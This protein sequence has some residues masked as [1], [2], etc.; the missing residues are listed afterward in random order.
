[1]IR[2]PWRAKPGE[3]HAAEIP[4][5]A[6][7]DLHG[8]VTRAAR[9][10]RFGF[11][12][13]LME[14]TAGIGSR[15]GR[16]VMTIL[17]T[18]LGIGSLV[19]TIGFAQT[20]A[21]QI[22]R[23]FDA[24]AATAVV[25][26]PKTARTADGSS[27]ATIRLPWDGAERVARLAGVEHAALLSPV[28]LGDGTVTAVPVNDPSAPA[29]GA[30]PVVAASAELLPAVGGR[31]LTGRNFDA[32]HDQRGDR[33]AVLGARVAER[34]K[35][36]RVD[37]QPS[38]FISGLAYAVIGIADDFERRGELKDSVIIPLGAGRTD[39]GVTAASELQVEITV[40]AGPQVAKQ[41]P[42]AL[43]PG[44]PESIEVSAPTGRSELGTNVQADVNIVF[45]LLGVVALLAGGL[46]IANVTML[47][48]L[49]RVGE[50][51]LRRA[52]GATGKQIAAQFILESVMIGLLGGLIGAS[53]GVIAVVGVAVVQ[54]WTP[55]IDPFLAVAAAVLGAVVGLLAGWFPAHR[56]SRIEPVTA[57]RAG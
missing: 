11:S 6:E 54:H 31:I 34:L 36:T 26:S 32:G 35:V 23:Q 44:S 24:V 13:L 27:V 46:G 33:V 7:R 57:L 43:A 17:G 39:F 5:P 22:A 4:E 28:N 55:I 3:V 52:L 50:I 56:A 38:I 2:L 14:A 51:G 9:A 1:M 8:L 49:E 30:P 42:I 16:L 29:V 37:R 48:V 47:S 20:A 19:A 18:V 53:L 25:I 15:P 21:G 10:D 40:G 12:D 41:A 45:V